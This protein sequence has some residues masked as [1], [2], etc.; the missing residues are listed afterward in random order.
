M[1]LRRFIA[2]FLSLAVVVVCGLTS[3]SRAQKSGASITAQDVAQAMPEFMLVMPPGA[4]NVFLERISHPPAAIA[5]LKITVPRNSLTNFL[6]L[7]GLNGE[8]IPV[9][10]GLFGRGPIPLPGTL[11]MQGAMD[12]VSDVRHSRQWDPGKGNAPLRMGV[13]QASSRSSP[14]EHVFL[15]ILVDASTSLEANVFLQYCRGPKRR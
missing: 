4:S 15:M 12:W 10:T 3:C 13:V 2:R 5:Y 14:N 6:T 9:P 7:S 8:F 1:R 11:N